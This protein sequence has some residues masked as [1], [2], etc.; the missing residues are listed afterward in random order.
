MSAPLTLQT[1]VFDTSD[2]PSAGVALGLPDPTTGIATNV[3]VPIFPTVQLDIG[4]TPLPIA[5][6]GKCFTDEGHGTNWTWVEIPNAA[7]CIGMSGIMFLFSRP[8]GGAL[9]SPCMTVYPKWDD[10]GDDGPNYRYFSIG[11]EMD[12]DAASPCNDSN[13]LL[14]AAEACNLTRFYIGSVA[15][16]DPTPG[17]IVTGITSGATG[18]LRYA[19]RYALILTDVS[20][21]FVNE[22]TIIFTSAAPESIQSAPVN[23][24]SR[25]RSQYF[26]GAFDNRND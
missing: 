2:P 10:G 22:E 1:L 23:I 15:P 14:M 26:K 7:D 25:W 20:G 12:L 9:N 17:Q 24:T 16:S 6:C 8:M 3:V 18:T 11:Q 13:V 4:Y 19:G 21:T 5:A